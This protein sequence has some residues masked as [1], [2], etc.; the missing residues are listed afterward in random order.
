MYL[1]Y[2]DVYVSMHVCVCVCECAFKM[3]ADRYLDNGTPSP[4]GR[5]TTCGRGSERCVG[6]YACVCVCAKLEKVASC[7]QRESV[8]IIT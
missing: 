7:L 8:K 3:S 2:T 4:F 6:R 1:L 5:Y